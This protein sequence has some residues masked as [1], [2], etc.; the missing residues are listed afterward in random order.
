MSFSAMESAL[1]R[2]IRT[3]QLKSEIETLLSQDPDFRMSQLEDRVLPQRQARGLER[4]GDL[5]MHV[6]ERVNRPFKT[7]LEL[8]GRNRGGR[9]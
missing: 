9:Q 4:G 7:W 5:F 2:E 6:I 1:K 8:D 3:P